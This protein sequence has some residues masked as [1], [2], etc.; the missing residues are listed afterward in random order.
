MV[1]I[2]TIFPLG[3]IVYLRTVSFYLGR[4]SLHCQKRCFE[5]VPNPQSQ[6]IALVHGGDL[7]T[8]F[9]SFL[10]LDTH[11]YVF[12]KTVRSQRLKSQSKGK[13][14]LP[15][16]ELAQCL[17]VQTEPASRLTSCN[18]VSPVGTPRAFSTTLPP[19]SCLM[20]FYTPLNKLL[21]LVC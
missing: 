14:L 15:Q 13:N 21:S 8:G 2:K 10:Q 7:S 18:C 20:T 11:Q 1:L 3:C 12:S 19:P 9:G 17:A 4:P 16:K 6:I 5:G